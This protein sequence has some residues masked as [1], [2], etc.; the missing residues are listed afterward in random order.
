MPMPPTLWRSPLFKN[1]CQV[2]TVGV[3]FVKVAGHATCQCNTGKGQ[4]CHW[5]LSKFQL[6]IQMSAHQIWLISL[7]NL[8]TIFPFEGKVHYSHEF[9]LF[10]HISLRPSNP[11]HNYQ[12]KG[13]TISMLRISKLLWNL[14][15]VHM[16]VHVRTNQERLNE[17]NFTS[18]WTNVTEG[19]VSNQAVFLRKNLQSAENSCSPDQMV[20]TT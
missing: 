18:F 5:S 12:M 16:H 2:V 11:H 15:C 7:S 8:L 10:T 20:A 4:T 17:G 3:T 9:L 13:S 19:L 1:G 14:W 6:R